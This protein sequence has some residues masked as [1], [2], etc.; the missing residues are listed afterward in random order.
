MIDGSQSSSVSISE[1]GCS[2]RV[3]V[4]VG[5]Y[6]KG[7]MGVK[8]G[9]LIFKPPRV[10]GEESKLLNILECLESFYERIAKVK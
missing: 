5:V 8:K 9:R 6:L 4:E 1:S 10:L 3:K 2:D 7:L